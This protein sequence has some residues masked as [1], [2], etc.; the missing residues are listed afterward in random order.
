VG[1]SQIEEIDFAAKGR[2]AG[3]N[4]GWSVYEG[5]HREHDGQA[6]GAVFPLVQQS[7]DNGWCAIIGGYVVRDRSLKGLYG[8]YVYGDNC[9]TG[10]R[11][12]KLSPG[13]ASGDRRTSLAVPAL[14]SF[15]EDARGRV[16]ATSLNG[17][18]YRFATR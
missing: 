6:P 2:A 3:A 1:Q 12:V 15:G 9:K 13:R 17:Q 16:Y 14:S 10:I 4:Y 8:R 5:R 18:V 7:H 11:S